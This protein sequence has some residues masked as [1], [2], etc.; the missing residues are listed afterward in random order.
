MPLWLIPHVFANGRPFAGPDSV[1]GRNAQL[2]DGSRAIRFSSPE[3]TILQKLRLGGE[4]SE[5][6]WEDVQRVLKIQGTSL[7][8]TY[9]IRS[10]QTLNVADLLDRAR[11]SAQ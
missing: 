8:F 9:L 1:P 3:D 10:A 7:D 5:R 4:T 11:K 6:Q 2:P